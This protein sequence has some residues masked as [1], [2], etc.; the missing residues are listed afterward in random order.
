MSGLNRGAAGLYGDN[1]GLYGG[2]AGLYSGSAGLL[3]EISTGPTPIPAPFASV[4]GP[5]SGPSAGP[6]ESWSVEYG[7]QPTLSANVA[8]TVSRQGYT[9]AAATTTY[10]DTMYVVKTTS[11]GG[12]VRQPYP[13]QASQ[14]A[15]T[16]A[17]SDY[18]Y[19]TDTPSG[20]VTNNSTFISPT[21]VANW[22][23]PDRKV[24]GNSLRLEVVAFHRN[25]RNGK[26]VACV[27]FTATD[28]AT[29]VTSTVTTPT[30]LAYTGDLNPV[31][32]YGVDLD[33]TTL[34]NAATITANAK[35]YPWIGAAASIADSSTGT[36]DS[37]DF[38]PQTYRKDT[39][40]FATPVFAYVSATGSD[41]VV[42][43][44]GASG[45]NTKITTN[46]VTAKTNAFA[47]ITSAINALK[48]ATNVTG[49]IVDG[50][51]IRISNSTETLG[52][53]TGAGTYQNVAELVIERDPLETKASCVFSF[54]T[55][56]FASRCQWIRLY[57]L[58]ITR[59]GTAAV[60]T[61]VANG[62]LVM[63]NCNFNNNSHS[64]TWGPSGIPLYVVGTV[65]TNYATG[66]FSAGANNE[67]R[68]FRGS[69]TD[70]G[71]NVEPWLVLG[72]NFPTVI[73][74]MGTTRSMSGAIV[75]FSKF[76]SAGGASVPLGIP[77]GAYVGNI[78]GVAIVQNVFEWISTTSNPMF[79]PSGDDQTQDL[80]HLIVHNNTFAGAWI[81][82]RGNILYDE[83][84]ADNRSHKLQSFVGNIHTQ[85]NNKGDVFH[86]DGAFIGNWGYMYGV[87]C[88]G[89]WSQYI[90]AGAG[91][92]GTSFAQAYGGVGST[93]GTVSGANPAMATSNFAGYA[94]VTWN[95]S[96]P[97]A[98]AGN[99]TYSGTLASVK[100][101]VPTAVLPYDLAGT[102]RPAT[103]DTAGAYVAP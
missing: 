39:T 31:I 102:A 7:S 28:G 101:T 33:I 47:T 71:G 68:L 6:Y 56:A 67:N 66:L 86:T 61:T 27:V 38:C 34:N 69:S 30:V 3:S 74:S 4:N 85:I 32:G 49:G 88:F 83:T 5:L 96:A 82:G 11:A 103:L 1:A 97:S 36:P 9:A 26:Q 77:Q 89:E 98:G 19:S 8:F 79:K 25:A 91:G 2:N 60:F 42:D 14:S 20:S 95:G 55:T 13:N 65:V 53:N 15:T 75:A 62:K 37:R 64:A 46:A 87:G 17:L 84:I 50:C 58:T 43:V 100:A 51:R 78:T 12:A 90:D 23:L 48:A 10:L 70:V 21:P 72:C 80:T 76:L 16:A 57:D 54:G 18:I 99:G 52:A 63:E 35:V 41:A 40:K 94:A 24:V 29:T 92:L 59:T 93:I 81:Y 45:G 44:N 73:L 22:A